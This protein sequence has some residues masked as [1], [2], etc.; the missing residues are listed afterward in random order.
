VTQVAQRRNIVR[1]ELRMLGQ[2]PCDDLVRR[3]HQLHQMPMV[4]VS[5]RL[6]FDNLCQMT[7]PQDEVRDGCTAA[8]G[9]MPVLFYQMIS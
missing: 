5:P 4:N 1:I 3:L 6:K 7:G 2:L 9:R 8:V